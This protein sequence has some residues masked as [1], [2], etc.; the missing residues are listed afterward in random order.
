MI[1]NCNK[2]HLS[3][4]F[5]GM[6]TWEHEVILEHLSQLLDDESLNLAHILEDYQKKPVA[7][8]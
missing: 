1:T 2:N 5:N 8:A 6:E 3:R 4:E 7:S